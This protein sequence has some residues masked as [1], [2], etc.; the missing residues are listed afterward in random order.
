MKGFPEKV[1]IEQRW[2]QIV[3]SC[4]PDCADGLGAEIAQTFAVSVEMTGTG[5]CFYLQEDNFL[6]EGRE[7]LERV[8]SE[9][10]E[11]WRI[12]AL[13]TY[14]S[15]FF[16]EDDWL[17]KWKV[18][19]KPLRVGKHWIIAPT[20]E[21]VHADPE[22]RVIQIDPGRAFGTGHHETTRLCLEW[23]EEWS[24]ALCDTSS[25]SL[26]D[27]GTGSG[28]L[29]IAAALL[30]F[31]RIVAVDNDQEAIEVAR[32]NISLNGVADKIVLQ[33]GTAADVESRF[34]VILANIQALPLIKMAGHLV[35]CLMDS[36]RLVLSG[37]LLEQKE[38]VQAAYET[39]GL[40][41]CSLNTAGEWCLLEF[42]RSKG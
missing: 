21:D 25:R 23:L 19:F 37:V 39:E 2:I 3:V 28:I 27:V 40:T 18:N 41:L 5:V 36:A 32:E 22:D 16:A 1:P 6:A 9:Y 15:S 30:G 7:R 4:D 14:S 26:L 8:L 38:Q 42:V 13:P 17:E 12:D 33:T 35:S 11:T 24:G 34:A 20:W 31:H 10:R 29:A